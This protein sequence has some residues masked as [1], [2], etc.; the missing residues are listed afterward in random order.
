MNTTLSC[1]QS[2]CLMQKLAPGFESIAPA[3]GFTKLATLKREAANHPARKS[4][5]LLREAI[6]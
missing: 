2:A 3:N 1:P 6:L 4:L 5:G